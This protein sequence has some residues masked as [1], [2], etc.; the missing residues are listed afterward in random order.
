MFEI[1]HYWRINELLCIYELQRP[2]V[3]SH[4]RRDALSIKVQYSYNYTSVIEFSKI[5]ELITGRYTCF[6]TEE[7]RELNSH[8]DIFVPGLELFMSQD[9]KLVH[10][11][12]EHE[13]ERVESVIIPCS[14]SDPN[15]SVKLYTVHPENVS[16]KQSQ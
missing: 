8:Y 15:A 3:S 9:N 11:Y 6:G 16:V 10:V 14:V 2:F 1:K 5:D 13:E 4:N 12:G 7:P